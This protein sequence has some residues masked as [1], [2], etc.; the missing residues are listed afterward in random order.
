VVEQARTSVATGRGDVSRSTSGHRTVR[1]AAFDVMRQFGLTTIFGNPGSTEIHFLTDLPSDIDFV[2]GLH[3]GSVVGMATGYAIAHGEPAFVNL[4]TAAGLGNAINAIANA[5]DAR[6]PLVVVVGQQDR[7][8]VAFEPFLT[9]RHLDR[10]AGEYPVWTNVPLRPQDVPGVIARAYHEAQA[11]QGPALL[12]VPMGDWQEPADDLAA[13]TPDRVLR[14]RSVAP[15]EVAELAALIADAES[16]A[17]VVGPGADSREGWEAVVSLAERLRC[18]AWQETFSRRA[19]FPQDHPLFAGHMPWRRRLVRETLAPHDLVLAVGT[20]AF[21]LYLLDEP[22]PP[23]APG[24]HVAVITEDPAEAHRSPCELAIV[25]PVAS[26][27]AAL[28]PQVARRD[29]TPPEPF[30]RP[31]PPAPPAPGEPLQAAHVLAALAQRLPLDAVLVEETPSSQPELYRRIAIRAPLGFVGTA[32]GGLGFGLSGS[33]GLRMGLPDRPVI[34]VI[35]DGSSIYAIQSLWSAA[36]YNVGVLIIVMA[37]GRYAVM[38]SLA[39]SV[40]GAQPWPGFATVDIAGL[41]SCFGCPSRRVETHD[42]LLR[43]LD[44]VLPGLVAR[45]EPLLLEVVI[46]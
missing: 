11:A 25:G 39:E 9:G 34:G 2:L 41:A 4:H 44:E 26:V 10:L 5:R 24:T 21:R 30:Q 45:R 1:D 8:Q 38:D 40:G 33:I 18:P 28:A 35:G 14:P 36:Q 43:T 42:E 16:P 23:V 22:G 27:C 32:N 3:E 29:V 6:A 17:I 7:R 46:A 12:V 19:G 13:G 31:A 20:N 15:E 37:N